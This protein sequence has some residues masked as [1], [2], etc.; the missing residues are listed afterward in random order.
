ML[1]NQQVWGRQGFSC[2][3]CLS[4]ETNN[5]RRPLEQTR[6][7]WVLNLS[8]SL[9]WIFFLDQWWSFFCPSAYVPVLLHSSPILL[10]VPTY[11]VCSWTHIMFVTPGAF[12]LSLL[13]SSKTIR[14]WH[15]RWYFTSSS[16]GIGIQFST[17]NNTTSLYGHWLVYRHCAKLSGFFSCRWWYPPVKLQHQWDFLKNGTSLGTAPEDGE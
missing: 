9:D 11:L 17:S 14:N 16:R 7:V 12:V 5:P 10:C 4:L 15:E 13:V 8:I 2:T 6:Y 3:H 1:G